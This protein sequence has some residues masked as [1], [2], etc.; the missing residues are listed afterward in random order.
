MSGIFTGHRVTNPA[1]FSV[2]EEG[3]LINN[4]NELL[5]SLEMFQ[6]MYVKPKQIF[7]EKIFNKL[8]RI[9][10]ITDELHITEYKLKFTKADLTINDVLTILQSPLTTEQKVNILITSGYDEDE[11]IKLVGNPA[12]EPTGPK[13]IN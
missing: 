5:D 3:G 2:K 13:I 4:S 12:P 10:G 6:S 9:N 11:A 1:I 7:L 8:A